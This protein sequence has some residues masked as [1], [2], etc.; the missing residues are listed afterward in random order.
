MKKIIF[1]IALLVTATCFSAT[2]GSS[3][4]TSQKNEINNYFTDKTI[5]YTRPYVYC[6]IKT[7]LR[8]IISLQANGTAACNTPETL[9]YF[10]TA[11]K[12][13]TYVPTSTTKVTEAQQVEINNYFKKVFSDPNA[14]EIDYKTDTMRIDVVLYKINEIEQ[15]IMF[16]SFSF[17]STALTAIQA[18][19][20]KC[21][22]YWSWLNP[23]IAL[24]TLPSKQ[25]DL[26]DPND[27]TEINSYF[28]DNSI[29][30]SKTY[31]YMTI[32]TGLRRIITNKT[33]IMKAVTACQNMTE[34]EKTII[35]NY[36]NTASKLITYVPNSSVKLTTSQKSEMNQYFFDVNGMDYL[37][38]TMRLDT[39]LSK[40]QEI[41]QATLLYISVSGGV[42]DANARDAIFADYKKI[43][44]I[45]QKFAELGLAKM[46]PPLPPDP[47]ILSDP[48]MIIK[49]PGIYAVRKYWFE[50]NIDFYDKSGHPKIIDFADYALACNPD[51]FIFIG[52]NAGQ[53]KA[54]A[55]ESLYWRMKQMEER[56]ILYSND[57]NSYQYLNGTCHGFV[58]DYN[59]LSLLHET[60]IPFYNKNNITPYK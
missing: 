18:D 11:S 29:N 27:K 53:T 23:S 10:T 59:M 20:V 45:R 28:T 43:E 33:N 16:D 41:N 5:N 55:F 12:L 44:S 56:L 48:N 54:D 58:W 34:T 35:N 4:T 6:T 57:P 19:S 32:K 49:Y 50:T 40:L 1:L 25:G 38:D 31:V 13:I 42:T 7:G 15:N 22:K 30:Y 51:D 52:N 21:M 3:L 17:P 24:P 47:S 37:T 2:Q 14:L 36:F 9:E 46:Y 39:I 8:K 26:L 60:L